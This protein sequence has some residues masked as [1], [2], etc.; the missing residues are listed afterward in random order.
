MAGEI[1]QEVAL[2]P[3]FGSAAIGA[4]GAVISQVVAG[5]ITSKRERRK[6]E[7][8]ADRWKAEADA[9]RRD[10]QLDRKI[11]LFSEFLSTI[12]EIET[13]DMWS[14]RK[15][16]GTTRGSQLEAWKKL[17]LLAE[18]IGILAPELYDYADIAAATAGRAVMGQMFVDLAAHP[19]NKVSFVVEAWEVTEQRESLS[20][21]A[22][23]FRK[24]TRS[25]ISHEPVTP[26]QDALVTHDED[27][28]KALAKRQQQEQS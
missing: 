5:V 1:A 20:I 9:K 28:Q 16:T 3:A 19:A 23:L 12:R 26:Y 18:E 7:A 10:R 14:K 6:A 24:A 22:R 15:T 17:R 2:A 4:S 8:D 21:W 25:Y 27:L 11:E 13:S